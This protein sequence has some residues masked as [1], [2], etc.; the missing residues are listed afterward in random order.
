MR[1][2]KPQIGNLV[3]LRKDQMKKKTEVI[4]ARNEKEPR[5]KSN[6][7][8]CPRR[9]S[10]E[11]QAEWRRIVKLYRELEEPIITDLDINALEVYCEAVVSFKNTMA[12]VRASGEVIRIDGVWKMNPCL[13]TANEASNVIRRYG[14]ILLLDPVSRARVGLAKAKQETD[15]DAYLFGE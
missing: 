12:K 5:I 2:H 4:N 6:Y 1:G 8:V 7:L 14:E 9:L 15:P 3:T 13:R 10:K 11:V